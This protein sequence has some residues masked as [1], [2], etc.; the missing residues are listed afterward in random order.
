MSNNSEN[1]QR[2][3]I[4]FS[5]HAVKIAVLCA[6]TFTIIAMVFA[7]YT[8]QDKGSDSSRVAS[9]DVKAVDTSAWNYQLTELFCRYDISEEVDDGQYQY[10]A[11]KVT[12]KSD[13]EVD[14]RYT[15]DS[16]EIT[17]MLPDYVDVYLYENAD[18]SD[19]TYPEDDGNTT[20][21]EG[22]AYKE[23]KEEK[24]STPFS[25]DNSVVYEATKINNKDSNDIITSTSVT[26]DKAGNE[27]GVLTGVL[28]TAGGE[29]E[30]DEFY[31]IFKVDFNDFNTVIDNTEP[32]P[33]NDDLMYKEPG[34]SA[35]KEDSYMQ[36]K[37]EFDFE[38]DIDFVQ[39]D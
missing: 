24:D 2:K 26:F 19:A 7:S 27:T 9:F 4:R 21:T 14:V 39:V 15:V 8:T 31:I 34:E 13:S 38:I 37:Q 6:F 5:N 33:F 36:Y 11:Y 22:P 17:N 35:D 25:V 28:E 3:Q 10:L 29:T 23:E 18:L 16:M 1:N 20:V 12:V 32:D 30:T